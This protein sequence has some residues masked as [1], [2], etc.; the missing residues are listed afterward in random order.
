MPRTIALLYAADRNEHVNA[1]G[2]MRARA[3][4]GELVISDRYLFSSL[5]YQSIECGFDYV[6]ALNADFP[7]PGRLFFIDT[8][9]EVCQRRIHR[10]GEAELFD[11]LDFQRKVREAYFASFERFRGS[12]M[13]LCILDGE[14]PEEDIHAEIWKVMC[15]LPIS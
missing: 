5:A 7:L 1:D 9:A 4:R 13:R 10:R 8:P 6:V 12:G 11:D 2:G 15:G 3:A 14:L